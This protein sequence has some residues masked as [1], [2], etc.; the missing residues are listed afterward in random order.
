M[1]LIHN[2]FLKILITTST[3][4]LF[5]NSLLIAQSP[6]TDL[7]EQGLNATKSAFQSLGN[8]LKV[9]IANCELGSNASSAKIKL[10]FSGADNIRN[11]RN[12]IFYLG[13]EDNVPRNHT[14]ATK[15]GGWSYLPG[16]ND[17]IYNSIVGSAKDIIIKKFSMGGPTARF[18]YYDLPTYKENEVPCGLPYSEYGSG[19]CRISDQIGNDFT[20]KYAPN[21]P[22]YGSFG[23]SPDTTFEVIFHG[24]ITVEA[25][26][27]ECDKKKAL[28]D[29]FEE[30]RTAGL[31]ASILNKMKMPEEYSYPGRSPDD[32]STAL[33]QEAVIN[34]GCD[35]KNC[36]R[37]METSVKNAQKIANEFRQ[38][39]IQCTD[40]KGITT[41]LKEN[42]FLPF[43]YNL[44]IDK[45]TFKWN[46]GGGFQKQLKKF[47][48]F[49]LVSPWTS[50][51]KPIPLAPSNFCNRAVFANY[52]KERQN[53]GHVYLTWCNCDPK[54]FSQSVSSQKDVQ[55]KIAESSAGKY[56]MTIKNTT[57]HDLFIR[58]KRDVGKRP[59]M[60]FTVA[61]RGETSDPREGDQCFEEK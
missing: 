9:E 30:C 7:C 2:K 45:K 56:T 21:G 6:A 49:N 46:F 1:N 50:A 42:E 36:S 13:F 27:T 35:T 22:Y 59:P 52:G 40:S 20:L 53:A 19:G 48:R 5:T 24:E 34:T 17:E 57:M 61:P 14:P 60:H 10:K 3:S 4:I 16:F 37:S 58:F 11:I 47:T 55:C 12:Y 33:I 41:D 43:D 18:A 25:K 32:A 44:L 8:S 28:W 29:E 26:D 23:A 31:R 51:S 54:T 39:L 15:I 38:G